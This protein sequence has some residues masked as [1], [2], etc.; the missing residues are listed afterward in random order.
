MQSEVVNPRLHEI[1]E[2]VHSDVMDMQRCSS[3]WTDVPVAPVVH[4]ASLGNMQTW[5]WLE[6]TTRMDEKSTF[7]RTLMF[8]G[9][10]LVAF[11]ILRFQQSFL[12][13]ISVIPPSNDEVRLQW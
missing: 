4:V 8:A 1:R 11:D 7:F 3:S 13:I 12:I 6:L 10:H 2:N 5:T 9:N